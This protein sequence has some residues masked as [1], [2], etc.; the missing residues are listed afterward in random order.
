MTDWAEK[1]RQAGYSVNPP[2]ALQEIE[3]MAAVW[4]VQLPPEI[5]QLYL[6]C[7]GQPSTFEAGRP[8]PFE[9]MTVADVIDAFEMATADIDIF[10][11]LPE[12]LGSGLPLWTDIG[13]NR[14]FYFI[15]GTRDGMLGT[16]NHET[17]WSIAP[18]WRSLDSFYEALLASNILQGDFRKDYPNAGPPDAKQ[19][20]AYAEAQQ[21]LASTQ[22]A[23]IADYWSAN[24]LNLVPIRHSL[25]LVGLLNPLLDDDEYVCTYEAR[26]AE[27]L[28]REHG[29][30]ALPIIAQAIVEGAPRR[31]SVMHLLMTLIAEHG[32]SESDRTL[33]QL[34]HHSKASQIIHPLSEAL[35]SRN[36]GVEWLKGEKATVRLTS[37]TGETV[38]VIAEN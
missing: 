20:I 32:T 13:G 2:A 8:L 37:P 12:L 28:L 4:Q 10:D 25:E 9:L 6:S 23:F 38:E 26:V 30:K 31:L 16:Q 15:G 21:K 19:E 34:T 36:F 33:W 35:G 5:Q 3:E 24:V 11:D 18:E 27:M 14:V 22:S 1:M 17:P 29:D 7:N